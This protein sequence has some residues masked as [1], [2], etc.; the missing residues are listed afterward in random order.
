MNRFTLRQEYFGGILHDTKEIT[1]HVLDK[2]QSELFSLILVADAR[3]QYATQIGITRHELREKGFIQAEVEKFCTLGALEIVGGE[4]VYPTNVRC[5]RLP[6]IP[7]HCLSAPIRVYHTYTHQCNLRCPQCCVSSR[8]DYTEQR[9]TLGQIALVM[10]KFYEAGTMEWRFTGGE[11]TSCPDFLAALGIAK[12]LGMAV[13]LNTNGCWSDQ[14]LEC[15]PEAGI[16]EV[17]VSLEGGEE[18]NDKRRSPGV[19][20]N[21]LKVLNRIFQYNRDHADAKVRVTV[22]MTIARDNVGEVEFVVRLAA[23]FGFNTNFVPLRPYGRTLTGLAEA[24]LSTREFMQFSEKVQQLREDPDIRNSGGRVIHR[25]MD[26][27]CPD[28]PDKSD[29][30][31][32]FN[33]SDCGALSTGFGMC[34]DGRVNACSFLMDNPDFVGPNMVEASVQEAWLHPR[35]EFFRRA[36]KVGCPSCRFY[37]KQCEGKCRAMVLANGGK[38]ADGKLIGCD[39]YCFGGLM[40]KQ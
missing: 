40:P 15:L 35:M 33:Y 1:C 5:V 32:P 37:M 34:P 30:P 23:S 18:V 16:G 2:R 3:A 9:M 4:V 24:T 25:N 17:I 12:G 8:A 27:F 19:Y 31:Y 7:A 10:N 38:I 6:I 29:L 28:Y 20:Q 14:L 11:P 13:M 36:T 22:N 21:V 39:P 26:L